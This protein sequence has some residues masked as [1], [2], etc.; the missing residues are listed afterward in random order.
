[1]LGNFSKDSRENVSRD[2]Y[3]F[4][5]SDYPQLSLIKFEAGE[6]QRRMKQMAFSQRFMEVGKVLLTHNILKY[7]PQNVVRGQ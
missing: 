2:F 6:A 5:R 4:H 1:M 3:F 7:S